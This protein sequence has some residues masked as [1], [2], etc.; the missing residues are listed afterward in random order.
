M[1]VIIGVGSGI[2]QAM[3]LLFAREGA[4]LLATDVNGS[5]NCLCR[6]NVRGAGS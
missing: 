2:G 4:H 6:R 3:A 1:S 5:Q